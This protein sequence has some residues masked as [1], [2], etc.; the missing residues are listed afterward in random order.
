MCPLFHVLLH[1]WMISEYSLSLVELSSKVPKLRDHF[2]FTKLW[3]GNE[4]HGNPWLWYLSAF[5]EEASEFYC[6]FPWWLHQMET[7]SVLLAICAGNSPIPGEFPAQRPV[8]RSFD[9]FFDLRLNKQLS[10]QSWG[11]WLETLLRP[12]WRQ[13]NACEKCCSVDYKFVIYDEIQIWTCCIIYK[14]E[15]NLHCKVKCHKMRI[16]VSISVCQFCNNKYQLR[17]NIC[18]WF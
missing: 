16:H 8:T 11:W 4:H 18:Y 9:V 5:F 13:C 10:K 14:I 17:N 7:F 3:K 12:L 1:T 15:T 2:P 6:N